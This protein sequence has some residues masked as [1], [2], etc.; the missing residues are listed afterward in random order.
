MLIS[1]FTNE[2][3]QEAQSGGDFTLLPPGQY[4][5]VVT[6]AE[7]KAP[8]NNP[9]GLMVAVEFK[10]MGGQ[11]NGVTVKNNYT[12]QNSNEKA[13]KIG[14]AQLKVLCAALG[15]PNL[16][17]V[18]Q[19]IQPT[20]IGLEIA[21]RSYFAKDGTEKKANDVKK[22]LTANFENPKAPTVAAT[23]ATTATPPWQQ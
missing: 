15:L 14:V 9:N 11:Y 5:A 7:M 21:N 19:L 6:N 20:L 17:V 16:G 3:L 13:V 2:D 12:Y 8:T 18:Q 1:G 23:P 10:I 22:V 4:Q